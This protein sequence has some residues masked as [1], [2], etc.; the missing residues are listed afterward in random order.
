MNSIAGKRSLLERA[1]DELIKASGL[2]C[3]TYDFGLCGTV[4]HLF[5]QG[6]MRH[7]Y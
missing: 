5:D 4:D 3:I 7:V 2:S 1:D 6:L